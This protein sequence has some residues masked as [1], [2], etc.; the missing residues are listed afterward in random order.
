MHASPLYVAVQIPIRQHVLLRTSNKRSEEGAT[1]L[2]QGIMRCRKQYS[3]SHSK[4]VF[5]WCSLLYR[6]LQRNQS[7]TPGSSRS[8]TVSVRIHSRYG[9]SNHFSLVG[10]LLTSPALRSSKD[11]C[12]PTFFP[13]HKP[14]QQLLERP[15]NMRHGGEP[16]YR[17][18]Q[19]IDPTNGVVD[20]CDGLIY[21]VSLMRTNWS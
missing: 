3:C 7:R 9:K 17:L 15:H 19:S 10:P 21:V 6:L 4:Q 1:Q 11:C 18:H 8:S 14:R 2:I 13:R 12:S 20:R 5:K 16:I